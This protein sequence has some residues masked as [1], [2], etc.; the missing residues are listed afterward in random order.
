MTIYKIKPLAAIGIQQ[1]TFTG[2][3]HT[4]KSVAD[5]SRYY[6]RSKI[7]AA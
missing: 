7:F 4:T 2:N 5:L 3:F 1:K 6:V